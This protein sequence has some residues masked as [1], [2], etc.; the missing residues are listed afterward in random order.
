MPAP[1]SEA[2]PQSFP[3]G[4]ASRSESPAATAPMNT[5]TPAGFPVS[6]LATP[7]MAATTEA[8]AGKDRQM[9]FGQG[10]IGQPRLDKS[11][12]LRGLHR[13]EPR[14]RFFDQPQRS[15]V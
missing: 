11:R 6:L 12:R 5:R 10:R 4:F 9:S 14:L 1:A 8:T 7:P 2:P 13:Y 15:A 3:R